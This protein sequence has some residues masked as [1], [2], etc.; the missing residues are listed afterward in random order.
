LPFSSLDFRPRHCPHQK[1][2][3][4]VAPDSKSNRE[5]PRHFFLFILFTYIIFP[6][7]TSLFLRDMLSFWV[8]RSLQSGLRRLTSAE[9]PASAQC[10]GYDLITEQK[11]HQSVPSDHHWRTFA[12]KAA[13]SS[14]LRRAAE[15]RSSGAAP[16]ARRI[17][18]DLQDSSS[19]REVAPS[20]SAASFNEVS[21]VV[22]RPALVITRPVEWGTVLLGFEQANR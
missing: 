16:P 18:R 19:P 1:L 11:Q 10:L 12:S 6:S 5:T 13:A 17:P 8:R 22:N 2:L 14:R 4:F 21:A 20:T 9:L 3:P 7:P 15:R